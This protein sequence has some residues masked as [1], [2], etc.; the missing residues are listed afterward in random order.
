MIS[1]VADLASPPHPFMQMNAAPYIAPVTGAYLRTGRSDVGTDRRSAARRQALSTRA[2][3]DRRATP[4]VGLT[5][6]ICWWTA[7]TT[8]LTC[9]I[10]PIV[11]RGALVPWIAAVATLA[12][13][14]ALCLAGALQLARRDRL[15]S[16]TGLIAGSGAAFALAQAA[17]LLSVVS[18][19]Q[20]APSARLEVIGLFL[21]STVYAAMATAGAW[22]RDLNSKVVPR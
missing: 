12:A 2:G 10:V 22:I 5:N 1:S 18:R 8:G 13:S 17:H 11:S 9:S 21:L 7:L 14:T 4:L 20:I 19:A 16:W 6:Q 3:A 15:D